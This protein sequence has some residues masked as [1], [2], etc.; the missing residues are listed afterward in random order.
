MEVCV[1]IESPICLPKTGKDAGCA[2]KLPPG[3]LERTLAMLEES[4]TDSKIGQPTCETDQIDKNPELAAHLGIS[5][6]PTIVF[7]DGR[8]LHG[9]K[10]AEN[11]IVWL[12]KNSDKAQAT[13]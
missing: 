6:I 10:T 3:A 12:G 2:A 11:S 13:K 8:V 4:P 1:M 5:S 9:F 7:P